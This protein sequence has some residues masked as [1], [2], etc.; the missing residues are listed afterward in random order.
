MFCLVACL[1][2]PS[3]TSQE[4]GSIAVYL[5]PGAYNSTKSRNDIPDSSKFLLS[6]VGEDGSVVYEGTYGKL[7]SRIEVTPGSY[8][9]SV[10]SGVFNKPGFSSPLYGDD[11]CIV[12]PSG[13]NV[14]VRLECSMINCGIRLKTSSDFLTS[15][16]GGVLFVKS[17]DGSLMYGYSEKRIAYFKPGNVTVAMDENG[18]SRDLF[19]RNLAAREVLTVSISAPSV[20]SSGSVSVSVDTSCNWINDSFVISDNV[21]GAGED[22]ALGVAQARQRAVSGSESGTDVWVYGYIA[23]CFKSSSSVTFSPPFSSATNVVI[24]GRESPGGKEECLSVELKKGILRD[25]VNLVSNPSNIGRKIWIKGDLTEAYYGIPGI[26]NI[27]EY[28]LADQ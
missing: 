5:A 12:V 19:T 6:I 8:T 25:D 3:S 21:G 22:S 15:Y 1:E 20:E 13:G 9:V 28:K 18:V 16:P 11:Q 4:N 24:A 7:P 10:R 23:G 17:V 27:S 26:K 14:D 2:L